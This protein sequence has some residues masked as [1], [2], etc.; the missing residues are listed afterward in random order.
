MFRLGPATTGPASLAWLALSAHRTCSR[1]GQWTAIGLWAIAATPRTWP[2]SSS[3][4]AARSATPNWPPRPTATARGLQA[5]GLGP[6][7]TVAT[8]L[9]N[10]ATALAAVLRRHR[11]RAVRRAGQLAPGRRRGRLHPGR[12]R[13]AARSWPH[14]R[15]A[16]RGRRGR[17]PGR[18]QGPVRG[19]RDRRLRAARPRSATTGRP[20]ARQPRTHGAPML[21]T[22]GTSGRPKG[23]RR[24]LTGA[25][26][27]RR[28]RWPGHLVL[29]PVR[30]GAVRRSRA[31]VRLAAVPHRGAQLRRDLDPAR[32]HRGADGPLGP[33]GGAG[34][35]RAAPGDPHPHGA[36]PVPPDAGAAR[37]GARPVRHQLAARGDPQRGALPGG[38]QAAA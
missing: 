20:A 12:Q 7:D 36:D 2:R 33:G 24:P 17:R 18:G 37:R 3:R 27:G 21:Y 4:T 1:F 30:P 29:R 13:G 14:E 32:P 5:L 35:H 19:R 8:L 26:P 38:G 16:G 28:C 11:D 34:P 25:R 9:P 31:P 10:S 22:S 6:G 15:F 23:V